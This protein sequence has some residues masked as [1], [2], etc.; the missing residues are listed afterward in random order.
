MKG[1]EL[2]K[3]YYERFGKPML[4]EQFG[5]VADRIACGMAGHGSECFGFDDEIS[6]DHDFEPGFC[7]WLTKEDERAFGFRLF[8]AYSKLPREFDGVRLEKRSLFGSDFRGVHTIDSFYSFY[9]GNSLPQTN[10]EW[11][12]IPDFY[13]A[14]ATNGAVFCDPLGEFT[15][16]RGHLLHNRPEDVRLKKLGSCVFSMAQLGQYNYARCLRHG[17]RGAAALALADFCKNSA[18]AVFLLNRAYAPYDKWL[19]RGM[20][21]LPILGQEEKKLEAMLA[22]PLDEKQNAPLIEGLCA[23]VAAELR[24]QGLAEGKG[25]Y[26]EPYAYEIGEHI[27]DGELRN[28][29]VIL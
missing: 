7:L 6:R 4:A 2:A 26:L 12:A 8:R 15:R 9:I 24:A 1:L 28:S 3:A 16:V 10:A 21:A 23:A 14:E 27:R 20:R 25:D 11:L 17:E 29:P 18:K 5:D 13:L 19:L 22:H